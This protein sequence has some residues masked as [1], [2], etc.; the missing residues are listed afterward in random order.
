MKNSVLLT[1]LLLVPFCNYGQHLTCGV[2]EAPAM[3]TEFIEQL[4][5]SQPFPEQLTVLNLPTT[6]HV[7][8][9]STGQGSFTATNAFE[10]LCHLNQQTAGAGL[11][12][13][14]P[15]NINFIDSDSLLAITNI[16]DIFGLMIN[17][18][19]L[20]TVN[21]FFTNLSQLGFCGLATFPGNG[22]GNPIEEGAII[23]SFACAT[24]S[25]NEI[26][27]E[28]GHYFGLPHTFDGTAG[29]P[30][31]LQAERVTRLA[32]ETG[33]RLSANCLT[34]GDRFC[35]TPADFI[36]SRWLCPTSLTATDWNGDAFDPDSSLFMS[37]SRS[38]C[39][40]RFSN[41]QITAM[42]ATLSSP[43]RSYLLANPMPPFSNFTQAPL[44]LLPDSTS[45][46]AANN[47]HFNWNAIAGS[48]SYQVQVYFLT[49]LV[50][51][52]IVTDTFFVSTS[53]AIRANALHSW[54][55]RALNGANICTQ[56]SPR[57]SFTSGFRVNS[58]KLSPA[59]NRLELLPSIISSGDEMKL[60]SEELFS[61]GTTSLDLQWMNLAGQKV[62]SLHIQIHDGTALFKAPS[63]PAGVYFVYTNI[64]G[65][66]YFNKVVI[67]EGR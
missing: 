15:T 2:G 62:N 9:T 6:I 44:P 27:H 50:I 56:Y 23:M 26:V 5:F 36:T 47:V 25:R 29:A 42:R 31:S 10:V 48:T 24:G 32:N 33:G 8:R 19:V 3:V 30:A 45:S 39:M 20:G 35:D 60:T 38:V 28:V 12:F 34:A 16:D 58:S 37:Y 13:Y 63:L 64:Q 43:S 54:Q 52:T 14:L 67:Q 55:V 40:S 65:R 22:P 7:V 21:M 57:L 59:T 53:N 18:N 17:H 66:P 11:F 41:Q 46:A 49:I 51:D 1:L 4:D 61:L